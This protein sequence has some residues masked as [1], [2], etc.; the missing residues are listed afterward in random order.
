MGPP[1]T[2]WPAAWTALRTGLGLTDRPA[3]GDA[4]QG[5]VPGIPRLDGQVDFVNAQ[6]LGIRTADGL[7]RFI[8]GYVGSFVIHQHRF[9][10]PDSISH[11]HKQASQAWTTWLAGL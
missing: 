7:I 10:E 1:V 6:A 4:V 11:N 5:T 9:A 2:D 3:V 8:Q